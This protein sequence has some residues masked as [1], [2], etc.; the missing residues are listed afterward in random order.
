MALF[1]ALFFRAATRTMLRWARKQGVVVVRLC[2]L[3]TYGHQLNQPPYI[4]LSVTRGGLDIK[5]D[6]WRGAVIRLLR[7]SLDLFNPDS[8]PG[9]GPIRDKKQ[10]QRHLQAQYGR[11]WKAHFAKKTREAWRCVK[12]FGRY[13]KRPPVSAAK[14]RHYSCGAEA[15]RYYDHLTQVYRRQTLTQEEM[16]GRYISHI[17]AKHFKMVRYYVFFQPQ[18]R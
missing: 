9:Q 10:W 15:H 18:T 5:H 16:I 14:L 6:V 12:Y 17:P 1:N 13:L 4:H 11:R 8:L 2:A 3:H 7:H